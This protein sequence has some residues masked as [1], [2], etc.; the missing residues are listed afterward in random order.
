MVPGRRRVTYDW[1]FDDYVHHD[2]PAALR[3]IRDETGKDDVHWV[4]H[5]MGGMVGYA[6]LTVAAQHHLRSLVAIGSPAFSG[7]RSKY[8][9]LLMPFKGVLKLTSRLPYRRSVALGAPL[10]MLARKHLALFANPEN[11][12]PWLM[13]RLATVALSDVS[14]SLLAQFLDWYTTHDFRGWY[15]THSY[16][17]NLRDIR[18]PVYIIAGA[19]DQLT[20][21]SD[22]RYIYD[23]LA[24][25]DKRFTLAGR[26]FGFEVDY[27]HV[28]LVLGRHAPREIFP[29]VTDWLAAH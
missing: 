7:M 21:P 8:L 29:K 25:V 1:N 9:D 24:S 17:S 4:G 3:L 22:I 2:V 12:D 13:A 6:F 16:K 28:D 23:Q 26:D 11:M 19:G 14:T 5:S 15:G 18:V 20:P 27:G 10:V